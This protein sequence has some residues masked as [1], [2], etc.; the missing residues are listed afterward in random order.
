[1]SSMKGVFLVDTY[2]LSV[3]LMSFIRSVCV[4]GCIESSVSE[5]VGELILVEDEEMEHVAEGV[6]GLGGEDG[7]GELIGSSTGSGVVG[8][9]GPCACLL[10]GVR[11]VKCLGLVGVVLGSKRAGMGGGAGAGRGG[12]EMEVLGVDWLIG[13]GEGLL[14]L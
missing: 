8:E 2:V 12:G 10:S 9:A 5:R 11:C 7:G 14:L 1:M 6:L 3:A 4:P 13:T